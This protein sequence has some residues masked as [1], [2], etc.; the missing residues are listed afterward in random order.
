MIEKSGRQESVLQSA[1]ILHSC[2]RRT[3]SYSRRTF[4]KRILNT[5]GIAEY[6]LIA[7]RIIAYRKFV[8]GT[9][10]HG[11]STNSN[12]KGVLL[13]QWYRQPNLC[14]CHIIYI[15]QTPHHPSCVFKQVSLLLLRR[16]LLR[17]IL[18]VSRIFIISTAI[19]ISSCHLTCLPGR[20]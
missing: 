20:P 7:S 16:S 5:I 4:I 8:H 17:F 19:F 18:I 14:Y 11:I 13:P 9:P 12:R 3:V 15:L 10:S 1:G 6:S 2:F